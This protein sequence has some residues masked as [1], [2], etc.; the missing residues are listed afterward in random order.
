MKRKAISLDIEMIRFVA[1]GVAMADA[2]QELLS[3]SAMLAAPAEDGLARA[4]T[5][6]GLIQDPR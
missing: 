2:V 4:F 5:V 3:V 1:M 6:L